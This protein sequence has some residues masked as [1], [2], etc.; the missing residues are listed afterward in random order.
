[1]LECRD[2]AITSFYVHPAEF[3]LPKA[4]AADLQGG[5]AAQNAA[6]V[7]DVLAGKK[8]AAR[9]IVLFNAGAALMVAGRAK[10]VREGIAQA[11]AAI[12]SGAARATLDRMVR[13]SQEAATV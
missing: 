2:G 6:I 11:A 9:D 1:V 7:S 8:G 10:N 5:D 13:S 3:G 4:A 12:D